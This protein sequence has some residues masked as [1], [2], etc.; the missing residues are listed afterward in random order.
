M[1]ASTAVVQMSDV[2]AAADAAGSHWFD[3]GSMRFFRT[4][5]P[6][7]GLADGCGRMWFVSSE[8][9]RNGPRKFSVRVFVPQSGQVLTHGQFR[10]YGNRGSACRAMRAAIAAETDPLSNT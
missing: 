2:K 7:T 3:P 4:R 8:A 5:L 1:R 9:P 10:S 6:I